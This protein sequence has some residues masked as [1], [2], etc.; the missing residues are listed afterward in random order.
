MPVGYSSPGLCASVSFKYLWHERTRWW[1]YEWRMRR[2]RKAIG[3]NLTKGSDKNESSFFV[4]FLDTDHD[5]NMNNVR[6]NPISLKANV[7]FGWFFTRVLSMGDTVFRLGAETLQTSV[8][9]ILQLSLEYWLRKN[10]A[11][12]CLSSYY[13]LGNDVSVTCDVGNAVRPRL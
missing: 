11:I 5:W 6:C 13:L 3:T 8:Q 1:L 10:K 2:V 7:I 4:C 12:S 9:I